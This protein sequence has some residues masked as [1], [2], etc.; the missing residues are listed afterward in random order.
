MTNTTVNGHKLRLSDHQPIRCVLEM[1][2]DSQIAVIVQHGCSV[3]DVHDMLRQLLLCNGHFEHVT[4]VDKDEGQPNVRVGS[5]RD[6]GR[7]A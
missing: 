3:P 2:E 6:G 1:T 5:R 7:N 4:I